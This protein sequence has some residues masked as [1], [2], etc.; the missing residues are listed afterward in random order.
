MVRWLVVALLGL[1]VLSCA[2]RKPTQRESVVA[3]YQHSKRAE[4]LSA[5]SKI[6]AD[7]KIPI[8]KTDATHGSIVTD[9]FEVIP[10]YCDCGMNFFGAQYPGTRR[11]QMRITIRGEGE[12]T[13][14]FEFE[15]LLTIRTNNRKVKCTSFGILENEILKQLDK[16]LGVVREH[17]EN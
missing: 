1:A 4:V 7:R 12:V 15:T 11:G 13:I 5:L 9:S 10:E 14:K 6:L 17:A 2:V 3:E 16:A 8:A